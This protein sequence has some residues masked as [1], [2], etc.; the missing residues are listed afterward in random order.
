[1][2]PRMMAKIALVIV[3]VGLAVAAF[4]QAVATDQGKEYRGKRAISFAILSLAGAV[5][6]RYLE[7]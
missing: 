5:S 1:M 3:T 6:V 7:D 2:R 4:V